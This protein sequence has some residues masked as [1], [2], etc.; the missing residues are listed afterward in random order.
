MADPAATPNRTE[1]R[2]AKTRKVLIRAA[3]SF[4]A[5]GK[6]HV[7]I[8][9]ITQTADVGTGSFYNHFQ[10]RDELFAATVT[11]ALDLHGATLDRLTGELD[12]PAV[13][14]A[15]SF[16]LTGRLHPEMSNVLLHN[17]LALT[18]SDHGLAPRALRDIENGRRALR[19]P[20]VRDPAL[21]LT[22]VAGAALSLGRLLHDRPERDDTEVSDRVT[23]DLLR[24][25]GVPAEEAEDIRQ[26]PLPDFDST[27]AP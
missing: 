25:F 17:G 14:F 10:N 23:V 6:L 7:P 18:T 24:M 20:A 27:S 1:R 19:F 2:K 16:R 12:D 5:E 9:E 22:I 26:Q 15:N 11:E 3:Q 13:V 8:L 4:L 21:T